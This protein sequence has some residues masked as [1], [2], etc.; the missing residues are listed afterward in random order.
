MAALCIDL[1]VRGIKRPL[2]LTVLIACSI[3]V[4]I[5][6]STAMIMVMATLTASPLSSGSKQLHHVQLDPR[7]R[8]LV[9]QHATLL[10][11]TT[12]HDARELMRASE[13]TATFTAAG[14]LPAYFEDDA[15][16]RRMLPV[17]GFT[18][19][20][21]AMFE[22]QFILGNSWTEADDANKNRVAVITQSL[23]RELFGENIALGRSIELAT[24]NFTIIGIIADW[25]PRPRFH[26]LDGSAFARS[27]QIFIPMETWIALPQDY[28]NGRMRC[29]NK[30]DSDVYSKDCAWVHLWVELESDTIRARFSDIASN[31]AREQVRLGRTNQARAQVLSLDDWLSH[32]ELIP[33]GVRMQA[34]LSLGVLA[35]CLLNANGLLLAKFMG[36][37]REFGIRRA[38]GASRSAI[39]CQ[40]YLEAAV[41]GGI[42]GVLGLPLAALGMHVLRKAPAHYADQLQ[43]SWPLLAISLF[44]AIGSSLIV[45]AIP[46]WRASKAT[47]VFQMRTS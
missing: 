36:R 38:L 32:N 23:A 1:A 10:P 44:L 20:A 19:S 13:A 47:P 6:G 24:V 28:G 40:C 11:T 39:F 43:I 18:H 4:G 31:Y 37:S 41:I 9:Q 42:G 7:P 2:L 12:L 25:N 35:V 26:D 46:A 16:P 22:M 21:P 45:G 34:W 17:R 15:S 33:R 8:E 14:W 3:A 27:E 30:A 5:S 29:W